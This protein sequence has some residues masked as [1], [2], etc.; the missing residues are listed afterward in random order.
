[1]TI[2][3]IVFVYVLTR[4]MTRKF[5]IREVGRVQLEVWDQQSNWGCRVTQAGIIV[6]KRHHLI[7]CVWRQKLAVIV[8]KSL[9]LSKE[10]S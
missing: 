10:N 2:I 4:R 7:V 8:L 5:G 9:H 1:M 6:M 3:K